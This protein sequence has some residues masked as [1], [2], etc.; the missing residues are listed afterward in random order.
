[1]ATTVLKNKQCLIEI[2]SIALIE[3]KKELQNNKK[4]EEAFEGILSFLISL[5]IPEAAILLDDY[6]VY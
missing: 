1:M 2:L 5:S 6:R 4:Y 3:Y